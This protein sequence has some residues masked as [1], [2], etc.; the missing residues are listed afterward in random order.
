MT[1]ELITRLAAA[2][3]V[4]HDGPLHLAQPARL[5]PTWRVALGV[6]VAMAALAVAGIAIADGL[7]P[8]SGIS[9]VQHPQ[10]TGDLVDPA[11]EAYLERTGCTQPDG[12]PCAPIIP[13]LQFDAA[14]HLAQLPDGQNVY[15]IPRTTNDGANDDSNLCTIVGPPNAETECNNT[16]SQSHPSTIFTYLATNDNDSSATRWFTFGVAVDGATSV[17]LDLG[18][19]SDGAPTG[20]QVTVPVKNN[21]WIY[22]GPPGD[23][24]TPTVLQPLT[25]HFADGTTATEPATGPGCA[26][27]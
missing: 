8:F 21:S 26:A 13:G 6:M 15:V 7:G 1:D 18:Q 2:N 22:Q 14:R 25:I 12:Q 23:L 10:T 24:H 27:C 20:P 3:P 5:R 16:V 11:T 19:T 17:T 4:P 9:S